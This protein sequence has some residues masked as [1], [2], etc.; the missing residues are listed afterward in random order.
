[1]IGY[2]KGKERVREA[3]YL[4][5]GMREDGVA[6]EATAMLAWKDKLIVSDDVQD[7]KSFAEYLCKVHDTIDAATEGSVLEYIHG[8]GKDAMQFHHEPDG[9]GSWR[10][11]DDW[12]AIKALASAWMNTKALQHLHNADLH[13]AYTFFSADDLEGFMVAQDGDKQR[14]L[15]KKDLINL[16]IKRDNDEFVQVIQGLFKG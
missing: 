10:P 6:K 15:T 4:F 1:M 16:L 13:H 5:D 9:T 14:L 11:I 8:Q 3:Y 7:E 2:L 12:E